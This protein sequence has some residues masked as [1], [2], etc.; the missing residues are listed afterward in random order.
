MLTL[1]MLACNEELLL[2]SLLNYVGPY[3]TDMALVVDNKST[4]GTERIARCYSKKVLVRPLGMDFSAARNAGL[5][6]VD[7]PW[8]LHLDADEWPQRALL[9]YIAAWLKRYLWDEEIVGL[10][11]F[12]DN[13][14]GYEAP[15]NMLRS[16]EPHV[17]LFRK[18]LRF[19]G[20][21]HEHLHIPK[22]VL[23]YAPF[24]AK[25]LHRKTWPRQKAADAF[26]AQW[27]EQRAIMGGTNEPDPS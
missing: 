5:E 2:Q 6:M 15:D 27:P 22:G 18:H 8:V 17:R 10:V 7:T 14:I 1:H 11:V 16:V 21:I 25:L 3:V 13:Q 12:R 26:Y 20:R 9:D 4:D 24:D 19:Q 23:D